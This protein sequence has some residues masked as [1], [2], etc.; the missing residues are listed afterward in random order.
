MGERGGEHAKED[1][2]EEFFTRIEIKFKR[3]GV[4]A[5]RWQARGGIQR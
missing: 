4:G 1:N 3:P 2:F 5:Q